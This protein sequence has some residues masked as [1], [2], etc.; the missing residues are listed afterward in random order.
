MKFAEDF[1]LRLLEMSMAAIV[2]FIFV[3]G[4]FLAASSMTL[5]GLVGGVLLSIFGVSFAVTMLNSCQDRE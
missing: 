4:G 1:F 3:G 2:L 5:I